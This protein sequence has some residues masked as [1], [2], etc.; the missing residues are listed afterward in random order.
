MPRVSMNSRKI[1]PSYLTRFVA[2]ALLLAAA[3]AKADINWEN[4]WVRAMPP[5]QTMT[6]AYGVI[7]NGGT[8]TVIINGGSADFA[9]GSS[10]I[11]AF[12]RAIQCA[13]PRWEPWN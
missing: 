5:T 4:V 3:T 11:K 1:L 13:W 7:T 10:C 9:S 2:S 8:D 6:A 12:R